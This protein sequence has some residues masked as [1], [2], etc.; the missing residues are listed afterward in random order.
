[1]THIFI[2]FLFGH[3][4]ACYSSIYGWILIT[5]LGMYLQTLLTISIIVQGVL[6]TEEMRSFKHICHLVHQNNNDTFYIYSIP[7]LLSAPT[8]EDE[9]L[10]RAR[11]KSALPKERT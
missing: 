9:L 7:S 8:S 2:V 11:I 5:P 1:M 10:L 6:L 3:C 4:A